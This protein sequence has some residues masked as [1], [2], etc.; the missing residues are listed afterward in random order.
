ML[1]NFTILLEANVDQAKPGG[2]NLLMSLLPM[3]L[4]FGLMYLLMVRPQKREEKKMREQ[5]NAMRVGDSVV[6]IGGVVGKIMNLSDDE[7]TIATSVANTMMTFKK[8]AISTVIQSEENKKLAEKERELSGEP[9]K[10]SFFDRF[11]KDKDDSTSNSP[12]K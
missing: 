12:E 9:E 5:I 4:I 10:K 8:Q 11:K 3:I 7:V 1:Q 2:G 6:T